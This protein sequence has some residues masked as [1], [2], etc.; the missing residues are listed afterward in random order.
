MQ[1]QSTPPSASSTCGRSARGR[2]PGRSAAA[3]SMPGVQMPH[4]AAPCARKARCSR[5]VSPPVAR[6]FDGLDGAAVRL[7]VGTRQAQTCSPSS[8][9]VQAPQSPASQPTL[10]PVRPRSS[11]SVSASDAKASAVDG[12]V[13]ARSG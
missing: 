4:C 1:R 7:A 6:P 11:R 13:V 9:T 8:S 10:V 3:I 5:S 2:A 12:H